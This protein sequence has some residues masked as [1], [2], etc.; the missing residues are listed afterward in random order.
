MQAVG[1]VTGMPEIDQRA[2]LWDL[3][4]VLVDTQQFHYEAWKR[5]AAELGRELTPEDY[6]PLFGKTDVDTLTGIM[7]K[8][9]P[10][11][12]AQELGERKEA[13]FRELI[14]G[15]EIVQPGALGWLARLK[16]I[17]VKQ[18]LASSAPP[19]NID[20][21]LGG[22][23]VLHYLDAVVS[24]QGHPGKPDPWIFLEAA[25]VLGVPAQRCVVV[26]DSLAG[27]KGARRAGMRCIGVTAT[28]PAN[29]LL[30]AGAARAVDSLNDLTDETLFAEMGQT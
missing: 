28:I 21:M 11:V 22:T 7:G 5:L 25:R 26:E 23:G 8:E 16:Q 20:A 29:Q 14:R 15:E 10:L 13:H 2:V 4:G 12:E 3:D 24:G 9:L 1:G 17:G 18:S 30:V 6:Q 19:E 27:V